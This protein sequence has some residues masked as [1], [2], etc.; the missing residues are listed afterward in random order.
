MTVVIPL[1][2]PDQVAMVVV[3]II[4]GGISTVAVALR[5]LVALRISRRSLDASDICILAAWTLTLGLM[6]TCVA[7]AALGGFGW[8]YDELLEVFGQDPIFQYHKV[9]IALE[10]LWNLSLTMTK[11]SV[12]LFY[13]KVFAV[14]KVNLAAKITMVFVALLGTS[15]FLSTMLVCRPFAYN[16]DLSLPGGYCGSQSAVFAVF[17][18]M[19]LVTDV[20]V[21]T[22]PIKSLLGLRLPLWKKASLIATFG[23]GA[24][25]CIASITRLVFL[26]KV[27]YD[28]VT[29]TSVPAVLMSAVE[30][31]LAVLLAC[32][33]LLR[34]LVAR[35]R[36]FGSNATAGK[37]SRFSIW[38]SSQ[39]TRSKQFEMSRMS[40]SIRSA[41]APGLI[42][43]GSSEVQLSA[44]RRS[45]VM[46]SAILNYSKYRYDS[47]DGMEL[48]Y[49][50]NPGEGVS[51]HVYVEALP[52][53]SRASLEQDARAIRRQTSDL[54][55]AAGG[56]LA[57][58]VKQ[59]W[60]VEIEPKV[61]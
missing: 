24:L 18:I 26:A 20:A 13:C 54:E 47:D 38:M 39:R 49:V 15:G 8:H 57:I 55:A 21:L 22:M 14:T 25:T 60:N 50:L 44:P 5:L 7:E 10:C 16:W 11:M 12:L 43:L 53:R 27:D 61:P 17:A 9:L 23:I 1:T 34:P 51:H 56:G 36:Q 35:D 28:D 19:N 52:P 37:S 32:I 2:K 59:E 4:F 45:S 46:R 42:R 41:G 3:A 29:Y 33:P 6:V 31:S 48:R 30:P 40:R 58:V